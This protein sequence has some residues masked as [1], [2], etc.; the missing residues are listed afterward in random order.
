MDWYDIVFVL[1]FL[2]VWFV[3]VTRIL[4]RFGVHT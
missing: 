3:L 1:V 2:V 4:P